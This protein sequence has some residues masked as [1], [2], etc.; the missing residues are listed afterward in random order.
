[1]KHFVTMKKRRQKRRK[2]KKREEKERKGKKK[3]R[4]EKMRD[5][6]HRADI[7]HIFY[8][9]FAVLFRFT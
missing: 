8:R 7:L 5:Y 9:Y 3:E 1:M 4:K 6:Y 2:E